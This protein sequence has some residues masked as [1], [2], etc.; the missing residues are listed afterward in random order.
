MGS[1]IN[2]LHPGFIMI[3][4]GLIIMVLPQKVAKVFY[5]AGPVAAL[6]SL[7]ALDDKSTLLYSMT[8]TIKIQFVH[9]DNLAM[10]FMVVFCVIAVIGTIYSMQCDN[11]IEMGMSL[12]YAGSNMAVILA[13]DCLS[14][15]IF[16][17]LAALASTYLV[18]AKHCRKSTR[19]AFRYILV[20][21]FGGNMLLVGLLSYMFNYGT[22]ISNITGSND[23]AFWFILIGVSVNAAVPPMNSWMP[24][25]YPESTIGGTVFLS[26][27]T[28]KAAIY[29]M[30]RFFAG[31]QWLL[32]VGVFM[33]IYGVCMALLENDLRRLLCYHIISQL[34]YMIAALSIGDACG[35]DGAAAHAFNHILY[36]GTL[37]MCAGAV[38][39]STG[40]RKINELGGLYKK[41]PI[42][43]ITFLIA[44]FAIS[45]MPF[46]NGFASKALVM[47][48]V[49]N[50]GYGIAALLLTVASA[51]TWLSVALKVN[52][53]VFF[54]PFKDGKAEH[55]NLPEVEIIR[56]VP[57]NM[58]IAMILGALSCVITGIWPDLV[59][60][61]TPFQTDGHPFTAEHI[62]EYLALFVGT[63][64]V[65]WLLRKKMSAHD[66]LSLDFDIIYRKGLNGFVLW[67]SRGLHTAFDC[68][69]K[70]ALKLAHYLGS[71]FSNP[72]LWTANSNNEKIRH[73][74]FENEDHLIGD[75][76]IVIIT[77]MLVTVI[78]GCCI[79][80]K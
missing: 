57:L 3:A 8:K 79:L 53:Y 72:Y 29:V 37:V 11:K 12:I 43:A 52:Y 40:K 33:A 60:N 50:A 18:Y 5:L 67:L 47:H 15:I 49:E 63:T 10:I 34:G 58:N 46:L 2:C 77:T 51:G 75:V 66:E 13:G 1:I 9:V 54:G 61:L 65:F 32:W 20:H 24:D 16:W 71:H 22:E 73:Y 48:S 78:A 56:P 64:L 76:I 69:E 70:V 6:L 68:C 28:T 23:F 62:A 45:G 41:M 42:T 44:S 30:I 59:Y 39:Y 7:F 19:A 27:F 55:E 21:G 25:A 74:S 4:V 36:K 80:I 31:T 17:E 35:I 14:L 38:I 26:S